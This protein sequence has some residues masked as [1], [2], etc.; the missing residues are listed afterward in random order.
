MSATDF[1]PANTERNLVVAPLKSESCLPDT[2]ASV[3]VQKRAGGRRR[4]PRV[5]IPLRVEIAGATYD[6]SNWSIDG[7]CIQSLPEIKIGEIIYPKLS[8]QFDSVTL[9][10]PTSAKLV[11]SSNGKS[12]FQLSKLESDQAA[13]LHRVI[14][15]HLTNQFQQIDEFFEVARISGPKSA[16]KWKFKRGL[17]LSVACMLFFGALG[18]SFTV[19]SSMIFTQKSRLAAVATSGT[20]MRATTNGIYTGPPLSRGTIVGNGDRIGKISNPD[21]MVRT[22][23]LASA[24]NT[25]ILEIERQKTRLAE[26]KGTTAAFK[27]MTEARLGTLK[28][29]ADGLKKQ[30]EIYENLI[31]RRESLVP[32]G[33]L[34]QNTVDAQKII[35]KTDEAAL[36]QT[37]ADILFAKMQDDMAKAGMISLSETGTFESERTMMLRVAQAEATVNATQAELTA[38]EEAMTLYSPCHCELLTVNV[39]PGDTVMLGTRLYTLRELGQPSKVGALIPTEKVDGLIIGS[40][41][42]VVLSTGNIVKG[43]VERISFDIEPHLVGLPDDLITADRRFA[44]A[45]V[46][47]DAPVQV[48]IGTPVEVYLKSSPVSKFLARLASLMA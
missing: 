2:A 23:A 3:S 31:D 26:L 25:A 32:K 33:F 17:R 24:L 1:V 19:L 13:V 47:L 4:H 22:A 44:I 12:G 37:E 14:E 10:F 48:P 8:L 42:T 7:I 41:A 6:A 28:T 11:W 15:D 43:E 45:V 34:A 36:W 21:L 39:W 5:T 30:M 29:K 40:R 18:A 35:Q 46:A 27:T 9:T 16:S 38:L 20:V